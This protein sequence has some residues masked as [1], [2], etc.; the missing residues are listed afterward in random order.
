MLNGLRFN[1][2]NAKA[3]LRFHEALYQESRKEGAGLSTWIVYSSR[4]TVGKHEKSM[5]AAVYNIL[6][7][8]EKATPLGGH[9]G[10]NSLY[11]IFV[12]FEEAL[13]V[14][15]IV[16]GRFYLSQFNDLIELF[17]GCGLK[18]AA[19]L[20]ITNNLMQGIEDVVKS[21]LEEGEID[22][23]MGQLQSEGATKRKQLSC[24][25]N[26]SKESRAKNDIKNALQS[27]REIDSSV[28]TYFSRS[29]E[30]CTLQDLQK[31][32]SKTTFN[33]RDFQFLNFQKPFSTDWI[34]EVEFPSFVLISAYKLLDP[35]NANPDG[36][37]GDEDDVVS[38]IDKGDHDSADSKAYEQAS[39][40][41]ES[42]KPKR[43]QRKKGKSRYCVCKIKR[44]SK[45]EGKMI[46][47]KS[48][49]RKCPEKD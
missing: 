43:T 41:A 37:I 7:K 1:R 13:L 32:N 23:I 40:T 14:E 21:E 16:G 39:N 35:R 18:Y 22:L 11:R 46:V 3:L 42:D 5:P 44:T 27:L 4:K 30:G 38:N 10:N 48:E 45:E 6:E 28:S 33:L 15:G 9:T 20:G 19:I 12:L 31:R 8:F 17:D 47:C 26:C 34:M 2:V 25:C 36:D 24:P 29:E 49:M